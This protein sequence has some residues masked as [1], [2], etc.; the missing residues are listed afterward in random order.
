MMTFFPIPY[1]DELLYSILARYHIRSGNISIKATLD[2]V[3]SKRSVSAVMDLPSHIERIIKNMPIG[4]RYTCN[5]LIDKH[6][7]Y[8]FYS[9]FLPKERADKIREYM[10]RDRGSSINN[11]TGVMASSIKLNQYFKFCPKCVEEDIQRYGETYWHRVHQI[12]GVLICPKH[13]TLLYDSKVPIKG[14][15]KHEFKAATVKECKVNR[16]KNTYSDDVLEKLYNLALDIQYI[17]EYRFNNKP[18]KWFKEQYL[19]KLKEHGLANITGRIKQ[20]ELLENFVD[21]YGD[22][23]LKLVQSDIDIHSN[24][25]WLTELVRNN[26]KTSHPIRHLLLIRFLGI[27]IHDLFNQK[28][29]YEPF[30]QGPWPCLNPAANHYLQNIIKNV[31]IKYSADSKSPQGIFKCSY[32]FVYM[33][34][35]SNRIIEDSLSF[36]IFFRRQ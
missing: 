21:Y 4:S 2:D 13:K 5:E 35:G 29:E 7:L 26:K 9:A 17:L 28:F 32:G 10:K 20:K 11:K 23:F 3:Y 14:F 15:N 33:R 12:V 8:S 1:E 25:N 6:T 19:T 34:N 16:N 27:S 24:Y 30:G 31:D 22:K 18:T 36:P